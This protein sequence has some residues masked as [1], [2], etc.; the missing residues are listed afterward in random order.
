MLDQGLG[1]RKLR[2]TSSARL[3]MNA[4]PLFFLCKFAR[5]VGLGSMNELEIRKWH[6]RK[7]HT[8]LNLGHQ[9]F[10]GHTIIL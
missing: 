3:G 7:Y 6:S 5:E 2:N 9:Q 4:M 1:G 10:V 8:S